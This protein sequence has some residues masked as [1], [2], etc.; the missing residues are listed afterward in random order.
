MLPLLPQE[1]KNRRAYEVPGC[2]GNMLDPKSVTPLIELLADKR[3]A[4]R[5]AAGECLA[6]R[7]RLAVDP[8][9]AG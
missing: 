2:F 4:V 7:L 9:N 3:A 6:R 1:T 8:L 5:A